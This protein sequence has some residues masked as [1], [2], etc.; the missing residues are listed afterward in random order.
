MPCLILFSILY[1][2]VLSQFI[3]FLIPFFIPPIIE[4]VQSIRIYLSTAGTFAVVAFSV[5][6]T[7]MNVQTFLGY[8]VHIVII[9]DMLFSASIESNAFISTLPS[10]KNF[11]IFNPPS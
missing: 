10:M 2:S 7:A 4:I 6:D 9:Y 5:I 3:H 11:L 8:P 1:R